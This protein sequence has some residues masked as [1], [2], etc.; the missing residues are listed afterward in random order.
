MKLVKLVC[1]K[2]YREKRHLSPIWKINR[3]LNSYKLSE[4]IRFFSTFSCLG[5]DQYKKLL[6]ARYIQSLEKYDQKFQS[7]N[8][9]SN[10]NLIL[11]LRYEQKEF[12]KS[13]L[14]EFFFTIKSHFWTEIHRIF[15]MILICLQFIQKPFSKLRIIIYLSLHCKKK[16]N[17]TIWLTFP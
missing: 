10:L 11:K 4:F 14:P 13:D 9:K 1:I 17:C 12:I 5:N 3:L 6:I 15:P 7:S 2:L 16:I 8:Q